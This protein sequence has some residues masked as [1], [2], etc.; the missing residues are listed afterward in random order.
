MLG[1]WH[2]GTFWFMLEHSILALQGTALDIC[3]FSHTEPPVLWL[4]V[5][6]KPYH[7][8]TLTCFSEVF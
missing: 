6:A 5:Y 4:K 1:A 8:L 2:F 7:S 3:V